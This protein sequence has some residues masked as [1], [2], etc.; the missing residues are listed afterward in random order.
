M[1]AGGWIDFLTSR[2]KEKLGVEA[3]GTLFSIVVVTNYRKFSGLQQHKYIKL[4][5]CRLEICHT[6]LKSG[7]VGAAFLS[8]ASREEVIYL[9]FLPSRGLLSHYPFPPFVKPA[10]CTSVT[11]ARKDSLLLRADVLRLGPPE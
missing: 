11:I 2:K 4:Q 10:R 9:P 7:S 1:G 3:K 8:E 5:F 6:R